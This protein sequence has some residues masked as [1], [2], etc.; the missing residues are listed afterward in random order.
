M[1]YKDEYEVAR[2]YTDGR[3]EEK[4][5][6][7]F[8]GDYKL[9][10]HLAPPMISKLDPD[11]G[12][13]K[14][15]TFGPWMMS[16]FRQ[17]AKLKSLRGTPLDVFGYSAE[18]KMEK[19]LIK[20]YSD[21]LEDVAARYEQIDYQKAVALLSLPELVRG[22]GHVKLKSIETYR[23]AVKGTSLM[24]ATDSVDSNSKAA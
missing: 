10:F 23:E 22:Y 24:P 2:L 11:S 5:K 16:A 15:R 6:Q 12:K 1:A 3:F 21:T 13:V 9:T 17:L 18:R 8:S 7:Q 14:K 20:E 19:A 4:I